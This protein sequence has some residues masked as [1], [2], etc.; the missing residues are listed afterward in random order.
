MKNQDILALVSSNLSKQKTSRLESRKRYPKKS[1]Q[2]KKS[3]FKIT[4]SD[5]ESIEEE[6]DNKN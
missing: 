1:G 6:D 5:D 4:S 2:S 3:I